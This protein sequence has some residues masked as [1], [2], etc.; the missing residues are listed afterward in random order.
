MTMNELV[1]AYLAGR[2]TEEVFTSLLATAKRTEVV[3]SLTET[4]DDYVEDFLDY[5][6]W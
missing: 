4:V 1:A 3:E 6:D 5:F 2:I